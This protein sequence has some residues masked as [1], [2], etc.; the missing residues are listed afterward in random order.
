MRTA[1]DPVPANALQTLAEA[2]GPRRGEFLAGFHAPDAPLFEEWMLA[3]REHLRLELG[4]ALESLTEYSLVFGDYAAAEAYA[5]RQLELDSYRETARRQLMTALALSDRRAEA[6][7]H[8]K[9]LVDLL[10]RELGLEP[11]EKTQELIA[12][13]QTGETIT[14]TFSDRFQAPTDN[15]PEALTPFVGRESELAAIAAQ[16]AAPNCRLLTLH[17][18]GGMGKTRMALEFARRRRG[19]YVGDIFIVPLASLT[20]PAN[21]VTTVAGSIG[22]R[23]K[24]SPKPL[25]QLLQFLQSRQ[26]LLLLDNFEHLKEGAVL[27]VDMLQ[28]APQVTILV[29]SRDRLQLSAESLFEINGLR[30]HSADDE[31]AETN[32]EAVQMF[33]T[34]ARRVRPEF[35]MD[36]EGRTAVADLCRLVEGMPLAIELA[37]AWVLEFSPAEILQ[38]I[39]AGSRLL[40]TEYV[41]VPA[42]LRSVRASFNYSWG[43]LS[44]EEQQALMRLSAFRGGCTLASATAV[45]GA[46]SGILASLVDKSILTYDPSVGRY[47]IHELVRQLAGIR[48]QKSRQE[49]ATNR[50]HS[51]HFMFYAWSVW[52]QADR[53]G[54]GI[55]TAGRLAPS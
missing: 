35:Q 5:R 12:K 29:T 31:T 40:E 1:P 51:R 46:N 52:T 37:A 11:A 28:A 34:Y 26:M 54:I 43:L 27:L 50:K 18:P 24:P 32:P 30:T 8:Y 20:S 15:L 45:A 44:D 25:K 17:G 14:A 7:A 39:A 19:Q 16:F 38:Q 53:V 21:L 6:V 4:H 48:L 23:L 3:E 55:S 33:E 13:N 22:L 41:D 47:Q 36:V 42:R 49:T 9:I 10:W 2:A